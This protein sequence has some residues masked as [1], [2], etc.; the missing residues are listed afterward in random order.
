MWILVRR[1]PA[2]GFD[3]RFTAHNDHAAMSPD[4][5]MIIRVR[6]MC[7]WVRAGLRR[8]SKT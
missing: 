3:Q 4:L 5:R 7:G 1:S 2:L 8:L 6:T